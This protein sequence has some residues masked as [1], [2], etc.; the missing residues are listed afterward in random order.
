MT[1]LNVY[2]ASVNPQLL[3]VT[4]AATGAKMAADKSAMRGSEAIL[5]AVSTGKMPQAARSVSGGAG[6]IGG[7]SYN[8]LRGY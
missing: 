1:A 8:A 5:D 4:G 3:A 6:K 7:A 2:A